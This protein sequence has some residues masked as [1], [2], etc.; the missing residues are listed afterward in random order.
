MQHEPCR[1]W[2]QT[3]QK[4]HDLSANS[5]NRIFIFCLFL[6][7]FIF[8]FCLRNFWA[9]MFNISFVVAFF[10]S[11]H[12]Y[13][14]FFLLLTALFRL[15]FSQWTR[16]CLPML[17]LHCHRPSTGVL[18]IFFPFFSF[19]I[20][21]HKEQRSSNK[22]NIIIWDMKIKNTFCTL[23]RSK[24]HTKKNPMFWKWQGPIWKFLVD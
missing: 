2:K 15:F 4:A 22:F 17:F 13:W 24:K 3:T 6:Y 5:N 10:L 8:Q 12:D 23:L 18:K 21:A 16:I 7:A 9:R 11:S 20:Y 14:S 19:S 1:F